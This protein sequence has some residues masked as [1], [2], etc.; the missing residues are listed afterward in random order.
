MIIGENHKAE[1]KA[2]FIFEFVSREEARVNR[3]S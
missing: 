3:T 1:I 2:S